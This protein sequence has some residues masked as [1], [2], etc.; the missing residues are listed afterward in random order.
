M[1]YVSTDD[2]VRFEP[3]DVVPQTSIQW[4]TVD[5]SYDTFVSYVG[6]EVHDNGYP[7]RDIL[8]A[9]GKQTQVNRE[10]LR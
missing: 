6:K 4:A 2:I 5:P 10:R 1:D 9:G 7:I 3:L 8:K